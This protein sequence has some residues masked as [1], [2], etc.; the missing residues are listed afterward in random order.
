MTRWMKWW[1]Y[2]MC[3]L[4]KRGDTYLCIAHSY[5]CVFMK[6]SRPFIVAMSMAYD[7]VFSLSESGGY[8]VKRKYWQHV[9]FFLLFIGDI[10]SKMQVPAAHSPYLGLRFNFKSLFCN[11]DWHLHEISANTQMPS[12]PK[13]SWKKEPDL[14]WIT[15]IRP[16]EAGHLNWLSRIRW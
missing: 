1:V 8:W 14:N 15:I 10:L 2:H 5:P 4:L 13:L 12:A 9:F 16:F 7:Y 11:E 6:Y 3:V